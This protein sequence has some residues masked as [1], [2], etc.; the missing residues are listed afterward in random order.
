M[1]SKVYVNLLLNMT[2]LLFAPMI[3]GK[4]SIE[5]SLDQI[6]Y[7]FEIDRLDW[8]EVYMNGSKYSRLLMKGV[9]GYEGIVPKVGGPEIPVVRFFVQGKIELVSEEAPQIMIHSHKRPLIPVQNPMEKVPHITADFSIDADLYKSPIDYPQQGR[10]DIEAAGSIRGVPQYLVTLYPVIYVPQDNIYKFTTKF[11][12][13]TENSPPSSDSRPETFVTITGPQFATSPALHMYEEHKRKLGYQVIRLNVAKGEKPESIR[14]RI[15]D[16]YRTTNLQFGLIIG[17]QEDVPG[18]KST[19]IN[20]VTDHFYRAI[21]TDDYLRDINGSDIGVGRL[22]AANE[23]HLAAMIKKILR[24]DQGQFDQINWLNEISWLATDDRWQVAEGTH[25]YVIHTHTKT[26]GYLGSFPKTS[27][28]G[29]DQL[30]AIT[31]RVDDM[32]TV[33]T[34]AKGR[35]IINYSGHGSHTSW[36]APTVTPADVKKIKSTDALPFVISNA[37]ITGDFRI[38]ESFAETWQRHEFGSIAF[39]GSMDSSYWDED[40]ILERRLFDGIFK[41]QNTH[42]SQITDYALS[43][44]WRHYGGQGLSSY[45]RETYVLFGDPSQ[46]LRYIAPIFPEGNIPE[47]LNLNASE[48]RI[49]IHSGEK[50]IAQARIAL[51]SN[52]PG[53]LPLFVGKTDENGF[54]DLNIKIPAT[55][56]GP[57]NLSIS[58]PQL[59]TRN[60]EV[61]VAP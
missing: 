9:E 11:R 37:C 36:A 21:D 23:T 38:T 58:G 55:T 42:F 20:G 6:V 34:I 14:S 18:K 15:Q 61:E 28:P 29:G 52:P 8:Q 47:K 24:Y 43:E 5:K 50:P 12:V 16:I 1:T 54:I 25:N 27:Q 4:V 22:S 49:Q 10:Y 48:T 53:I 39:W 56:T 30:Y 33:K 60:V 26:K 57:L 40:D 51:T 46:N 35:T 41:H 13:V 59:I 31:H 32:T 7:E 19:I 17:D 44:L 3:Y 2:S 45:Y